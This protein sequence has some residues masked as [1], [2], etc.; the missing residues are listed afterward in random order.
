M[1]ILPTISIKTEGIMNRKDADIIEILVGEI[2]NSRNFSIKKTAKVRK[3]VNNLYKRIQSISVKSETN[4]IYEVWLFNNLYLFKTEMDTL[5]SNYKPKKFFIADENDN[6]LL[7]DIII[8]L[9]F[10]TRFKISSESVDFIIETIQK[11]FNLQTEEFLSFVPFIKIALIKLGIE[12]KNSEVKEEII[13]YVV[14]SIKKCGE[15]NTNRLIKTHS[16]TEKLLNSE[17]AGIY[18][19]MDDK[20]KSYYRSKIEALSRIKGET[21]EE[22]TKSLIKTEQSKHVGFK[23][24]YN[25]VFK[26]KNKRIKKLYLFS[27]FT[28]PIILSLIICLVTKSVFAS[29]LLLLVFFEPSKILLD[30]IFLRFVSPREVPRMEV[31]NELFDYNSTAS[32][33]SVMLD[34][35][36]DFEKIRNHITEEFHRAPKGEMYFI[37]LCDLFEA[38]RTTQD[39]DEEMITEAGKLFENLDRETEGKFLLLI[40]KRKYSETMKKYI[41]KNRKRGAINDI[42]AEISGENIVWRSCFGNRKILRK[43]KYLILLDSDTKSTLGAY[44][45]LIGSI[46]HPINKPIVKNGKLVS[47][48]GVIAPSIGI[49]PNDT[50]LNIFTHLFSYEK[51]ISHY[52]YVRKTAFKDI[53]EEGT[54][55]GKGIIDARVFYSLTSNLFKDEEVLS[56]DI[57]E[58]N[59][60][61]CKESTDILFLDGFPKSF[62][63]YLKRNNRWI[64]GDFQNILF[65][66]R[67]IKD[68]NYQKIE[69]PFSKI[70]KFKLLLNMLR[71]INPVLTMLIIFV[72]CFHFGF[73]SRLIFF[74]AVISQ[75]FS[76][77]SGF[78]L[79]AISEGVRGIPRRFY[80]DLFPESIR[81]LFLLITEISILPI[82]AYYSI[83]SSA[84]GVFRILYSKNN[85]LEWQTALSG[86]KDKDNLLKLSMPAVVVSLLFLLSFKRHIRILALF[87][88]FSIPLLAIFKIKLKPIIRK[89]DPET[90]F[91]LKKEAEKIW[92]FFNKYSTESE[93]FLIPDNVSISPK[94]AI[95]HRTS[96]TN[97]GL[98]MLSI[99]G[100]YKL[101]FITQEEMNDKLEKILGTIEKL[102][103]YKGHLYNWYNTETLEVLKPRFISAVDSGNFICSLIALKEGVSGRLKE[104]IEKIIDETDFSVVYDENTNLFYIGF[105]KENDKPSDNHY[106]LIMSECR[107][108][109][110]MAIAKGIVPKEHWSTLGRIYSSNGFF[111]GPVSWSGTA[112]EYFMPLI[113]MPTFKNTFLYEA[114]QYAVYCQFRSAM[115]RKTPIGISESGFYSFDKEL[116]Y[117]YKAHGVSS[118]SLMGGSNLENVVSPYS[119]FLMMQTNLKPMFKNFKKL[120]EMGFSGE[121]GL[122]EAIDFT[123]QRTN[124]SE[125]RI[126]KSYMSHHLGMSLLSIVNVL[127]NNE[128]Q[129]LFMGDKQISAAN[130]FLYEKAPTFVSCEASNLKN[131][132]TKTK[133]AENYLKEEFSLFTP[134]SPRVMALSNMFLTLSASDS[135]ALRLRFKN[136]EVFIP[137]HDIFPSSGGITVLADLNGKTKTLAAFPEYSGDN[138]V[139]EFSED[140]ISY[141]LEFDKTDFGVNYKIC[142]NSPV[143][144]CSLAAKPNRKLKQKGK[145]FFNFEPILIPE[146]Q[147]KSHPIFNKMFVKSEKIGKVIV[148]SREKREGEDPLFLAVF[149]EDAKVS[150]NREEVLSRINGIKPEFMVSENE[151][152]LPDA[153]CL[154]SYEFN[155]DFNTKIYLSLGETKEEALGN[156]K[157]AAEEK[158]FSKSFVKSD[159]LEGKLSFSLLGQ[160]L[161]GGHDSLNLSL[162]RK[163]NEGS[164]EDVYSASVSGEN[165]IVYFEMQSVDD[166]LRLETYLKVKEQLCKMFINFDLLIGVKE[167]GYKTEIMDLVLK[168]ISGFESKGVYIIDESKLPEKTVSALKAL[169]CHLSGKTLIKLSNP[170]YQFKAIEIKPSGKGNPPYEVVLPDRCGGFTEN[171]YLITETPSLPFSAPYSDEMGGTLVTESSLGFTY[172]LNAKENPLTPFEGNTM[173]GNRGEMLVLKIDDEYFDLIRGSTV[174]FSQN[175]AEYYSLNKGIKSKVTVSY[176]GFKRVK[177]EFLSEQEKEI[178]VCYYAIP[179]LSPSVGFNAV[180]IEKSENGLIA[181]NPYS[182]FK[183]K[184]FLNADKPSVKINDKTNFWA[185]NFNEN[186]KPV[187]NP[188]MCLV[189]PLLLLNNDNSV[190]FTL[191]AVNDDKMATVNNGKIIIKTNEP[192]FDAFYNNFLPWQTLN[193]RING[194]TGFYQCG[195]AI[196]FRDQLQDILSL[197][198]HSPDIAK[199]Q[200]LKAAS[201]QFK[202]GDVLHWWHEFPNKIKGARTKCSDDLLWLPYAVAE[203]IKITEDYSIL[204]EETAYIEGEPLENKAEAYIEVS[205]SVEI[206]N[207]YNHSLK[208]INKGYNLG[209]NNLIKIGSGDWN[210]GFN[211]LGIKGKGESVWLSMFFVIVA[212]KFSEVAEIFGDIQTKERL[213]SLSSYLRD[214]IEKSAFNG[215][216]YLRAFS[217]NGEKIGDLK[218]SECEID[219]LSSSFAV[220]SELK[221]ERSYNAMKEAFERLVDKENRIVKLFYPPFKENKSIGYVSEYP[222]GLR[223]NGGQYT[224]A[225]V[226]F[227]KALF[228]MGKPELGFEILMMISPLKRTDE[229]KT[230]PYFLAADVYSNENLRGRGGWTIYTGS[231]AWYSKVATENLL[232]INRRGN[233]IYL[234]PNIPDKLKVEKTV[235]EID[236]EIITVFWEEGEKT[237]LYENDKEIEF[238]TIGKGD[239]RYLL[240]YRKNTFN[241]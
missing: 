188:L 141:F 63:S 185:G 53:L 205:P 30:Y 59:L 110:F 29:L 198:S 179:T 72:S 87:F 3:T 183:T 130:E 7:L 50:S 186:S 98:Y 147:Y 232:G 15:I 227:S 62:I 202:E 176:K 158:S 161:Y 68:K 197:I 138:R 139:C 17:N 89:V 1:V 40:R 235:I 191:G 106:D 196:G 42:C 178:K 215:K 105:N 111:R 114:L 203:Y 51:G 96:P 81:N 164:I 129:R 69:N 61:S 175:S 226:W 34:K 167:T 225:A 165:S 194:R 13:R 37:L 65:L 5:K 163:Y 117:Q 236:G 82:N 10:E 195:G 177:V 214:N 64:R 78:I 66:G 193:G 8:K 56:H 171:G 172:Y 219:L 222:K 122:Y 85:L 127:K 94:K 14:E 166:C 73:N 104:R 49:N 228:E 192:Y 189:V 153:T 32:V 155:S 137:P 220:L 182:S 25:P 132:P 45:K 149:S 100:A 154:L 20:T 67:F 200:I 90:A 125:F 229:Y 181:F 140:S 121:F 80:S 95:A 143:L 23:L 170:I 41:G 27:I 21:E 160:I 16:V 57:L 240:K 223:E 174:F 207:L 102:D 83:I 77:L 99:Y 36:F 11:Y 88:L 118:L 238:I 48:S 234:T 135:G 211:K 150:V 142:E 2:I 210:D 133:Y 212:D 123:P 136:I 79:S 145:L 199:K 22:I 70:S 119:T 93:N 44:Q 4:D 208:A 216:Y 92:G 116:N 218:N 26:K 71:A 217:D 97:I 43:L 237:C 54:F 60:L 209:S 101:E 231:A 180:Q 230:E 113:F 169:A 55:C 120:N 19:L 12:S 201:V 84:T 146:K 126:V 213:I 162:L 156:L 115:G 187:T 152:S 148:F 173:N 18:P 124:G 107:T 24:L 52:N 128:I 31:G 46:E 47:G 206:D 35:G 144:V 241:F 58:G 74:S 224:H 239:K 33:I 109:S 86:D 190:E 103:K 151:N 38:E 112:F 75:V 108:L 204:Y 184:M 221:K 39:Y 9:I 91:L 28:L 168:T 76:Y 233:K 131:K 6:P 157:L 134:S 159:S